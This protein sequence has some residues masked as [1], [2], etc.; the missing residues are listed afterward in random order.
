MDDMEGLDT[1]EKFNVF[2]TG[3]VSSQILE[4]VETQRKFAGPRLRA[5]GLYRGQE[6]ILKA[7]EEKGP[8]SQNELVKYLCL[9]HST[10]A[11]SVKR[12]EKSGLLLRSKSLH[13][14]RVTIV[15]LTKKGQEYIGSIDNLWDEIEQKTI[16][17]LEPEE[18]T[19]FV[20]IAKKIQSN[21]Q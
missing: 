12:M 6:V 2:K 9:N 4:L 19:E 7:L 18:I 10:I 16:S 17:G 20:R 21:L 15:T 3:P 14:K 8:C 5:L 1:G 11:I 13:D